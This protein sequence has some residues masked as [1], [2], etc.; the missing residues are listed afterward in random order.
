MRR[1]GASG[2]FKLTG[3]PTAAGAVA[4]QA[5]TYSAVNTTTG[6]IT[7]TALSADAISGSFVQ[8]DD[9]PETMLC[10]IN[11]GTGIEVTDEDNAD[12]DVPFVQPVIAG[13]VDASQI[14]NWPTNA[15]LRTY[16][17]DQLRNTTNV[18]L[19]YSF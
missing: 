3:P 7:I 17:R 19:D 18:I 6:V 8:P 13:F 2:T 11:D 5:V 4:T 1:I 15:V 12:I 16:V 9:G 10:L 14:I